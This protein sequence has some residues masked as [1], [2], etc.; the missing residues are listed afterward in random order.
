LPQIDL[1]TLSEEAGEGTCSMRKM[2]L[3]GL[4]ATSIER[5]PA[6][7]CSEPEEVKYVYVYI[8]TANSTHH[9]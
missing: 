3:I 6:A 5:I 9:G 7:P 4:L 8:S 1:F 2:L